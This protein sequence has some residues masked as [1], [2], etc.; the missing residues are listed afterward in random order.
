MLALS[1]N[2]MLQGF[3]VTGTIEITQSHSFIFQRQNKG[4]KML[5]D[6]SELIWLVHRG[7]LAKFMVCGPLPLRCA[8]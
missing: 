8:I 1:S 7:A 6:L 4:Q 2:D 3:R 5:G